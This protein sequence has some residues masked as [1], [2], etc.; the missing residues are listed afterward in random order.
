MLRGGYRGGDKYCDIGPVEGHQ[1]KSFV[2]KIV[3]SGVDWS[4][5]CWD[6]CVGVDVWCACGCWHWTWG[7]GGWEMGGGFDLR[8]D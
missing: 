7:N 1:G 8:V 4:H 6:C 3:P 5:L 2:S